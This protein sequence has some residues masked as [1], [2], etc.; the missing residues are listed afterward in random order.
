MSNSRLAAWFVWVIAS[1]FYAYQYVLRVMPNIMMEDITQ[2]F[3]I[4]A[5]VFG[6]YSG[7][8]YLGYSLMHLPIGIMLDRFGPRKVM[9]AC[10]LLPVIGLLPLIFTNQ[11]VY[12]LIGRALIG[13]GSSAA[14]LG[15]FKIIRMGFKEKHFS[16]MLSFSV[17]IGLVGA[18]YGGGPVSYL[19]HTLGYKTVVEIFIIIGLLLAYITYFIVPDTKPTKQTSVIGNVKSVF[20][21]KKVILLCC[22]AGLM[23]GPLEGFSDVWGSGFLKQVYGYSPSIANYLPSMIFIGMCFGSPILSLIAEKTGY[24]LGT[25][26]TAGMLMCMVFAALVS[27]IMTVPTITV[28][29]LIVGVCCAYQILAIYQVSTYVPEHLAGLTTAI[30]NMIIMIFGYGF[31]SVIG[32]VI[33]AY[34]GLHDTTAYVYGIAVIPATL[35]LGITGFL[36]VAYYEKWS[37]LKADPMNQALRFE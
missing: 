5:T 1:V 21:N 26:I 32:V 35:A 18:V 34:G 36:A 9:T 13:I 31:H 7:I 12:P 8:Y 33:N 22:F 29:F 23:L 4:D 15:T 6:Q 14:I 11:W 30:A 20:T 3:H 16:R 2:Q 10:I 25:I 37:A 19:C 24:Y 28:S 27:G 17:M